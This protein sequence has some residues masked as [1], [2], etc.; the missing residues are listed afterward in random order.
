MEPGDD[1]DR[2]VRL[3]RLLDQPDLLL[4]SVASAALAAGDDFHALDGLRHR[5]TPR[6]PPRPSWLRRLSGRIGGRS[7]LR[8]PLRTA[9]TS[10]MSTYAT[11]A[12]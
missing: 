12:S 9:E 8:P 3:G 6:L 2:Y 4:G 10:W 1:G 5:R 7:T 11:D